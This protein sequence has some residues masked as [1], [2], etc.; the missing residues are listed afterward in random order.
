[1]QALLTELIE[2][3]EFVS[4]GLEIQRL[5]AGLMVPMVRGKMSEG[6]QMP[7]QVSLR[8]RD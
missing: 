7:L 6:T 4:P 2:N 3:F 5:P 8:R 1:M